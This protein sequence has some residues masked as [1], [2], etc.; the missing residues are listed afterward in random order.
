MSINRIFEGSS[1]VLDA[2][3]REK[4]EP[5]TITPT[6]APTSETTLTQKRSEQQFYGNYQRNQIQARWTEQQRQQSSPQPASQ[7]NEPM[8]Q[9]QVVRQTSQAQTL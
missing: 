4:T 6:F 5:K 7:Q 8:N 3:N 2:G 1:K 9:I